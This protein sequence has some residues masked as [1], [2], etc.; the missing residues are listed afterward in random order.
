MCK[1]CIDEKDCK[2]KETIEP[3]EFCFEYDRKWKWWEYP[4]IWWYRYF[5]NWASDLPRN[6]KYFFQ[7]GVRGW[8]D[9]DVWGMHSYLTDTILNMLVKLKRDKHG[10]PMFGGDYNTQAIPLDENNLD[11]D[12][13]AWDNILEEMIE[14][15]KILKLADSTD[16][17]LTY[18]PDFPEERKADFEA[19]MKEKY[20][21]WRFTTKEEDAK[22]KRAFELFAKHYLNL[23]D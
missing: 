22:V 12:M 2:K 11:K 13:I 9:S 3:N 16:E 5:W 23:W 21:T 10:C 18:A 20:P 7:R 8:A 15:F 6:T 4:E 17:H 14:G 19:H 1:K